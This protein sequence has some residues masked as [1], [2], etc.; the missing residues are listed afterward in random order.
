[1]VSAKTAK[2]WSDDANRSESIEPLMKYI[3]NQIDAAT[4]KGDYSI[5]DPLNGIRTPVSALQ[6]GAILVQL[7][8]LGY[9]VSADWQ[10]SWAEA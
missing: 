1:M 5:P 8:E 6:R 9:N 10:I 4:K 7:R 2:A 3:G